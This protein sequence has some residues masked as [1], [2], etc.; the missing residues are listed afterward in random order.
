[1]ICGDGPEKQT[2]IDQYVILPNVHFLPVQPED[3]LCELLNLADLHAL[4]QDRNAADLVLPSKLGGMLASGRRILVTADPGTE[5]YELLGDIA[6]IVPPGNVQLL[7]DAIKSIC[8]TRP[9]AAPRL[10]NLLSVLS[11][12]TILPQFRQAIINQQ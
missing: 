9:L 12:E 8:I 11:S 1:V 4:P 10:G 3:R 6:T 7:A 5:L 2:L